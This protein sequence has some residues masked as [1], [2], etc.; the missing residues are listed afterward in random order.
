MANDISKIR[1][2]MLFIKWYAS[3]GAMVKESLGLRK[4]FLSSF[5]SFTVCKKAVFP[6][7]K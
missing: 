6:P 2:L 3:A 7:K 4:E 5:R 1:K